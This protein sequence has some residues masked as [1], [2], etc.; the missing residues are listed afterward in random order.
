MSVANG[1]ITLTIVG[2]EEAVAAAA[3]QGAGK[4]ASWI[5]FYTIQ[6]LYWFSQFTIELLQRTCYS[7][8]RKKQHPYSLL[9]SVCFSKLH[10]LVL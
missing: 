2:A 7:A 3:V 1:V 4:K 8:L 10:G 6:K 9:S 5:L